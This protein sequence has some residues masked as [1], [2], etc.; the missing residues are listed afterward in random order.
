M[1]GKNCEWGKGCSANWRTLRRGLPELRFAVADS[2][3]GELHVMSHDRGGAG[4]AL[5]LTQL[6]KLGHSFRYAAWIW[7]ATRTARAGFLFR[8]ATSAMV[9]SLLALGGWPRVLGGVKPL[10]VTDFFCVPRA[11]RWFVQNLLVRLCRFCFNSSEP[12]WTPLP[13]TQATGGRASAFVLAASG[14]GALSRA[15]VAAG[16][17]GVHYCRRVE[18]SGGA[19][20][21][22]E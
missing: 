9:C 7:K 6:G 13:V 14:W 19:P 8:L 1:S 16:S 20:H 15:W 11:G 4:F 17:F 18:A 21:G 12:W 3:G 2:E 10:R 5:R 22:D